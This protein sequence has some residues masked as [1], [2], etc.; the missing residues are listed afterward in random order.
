MTGSR[1]ERGLS[2]QSDRPSPSFRLFPMQSLDIQLFGKL[3]V[4]KFEDPPEST[5]CPYPE[6]VQCVNDLRSEFWGFH[7]DF[8]V[9]VFWLVTSCVAIGPQ[10]FSGSC[11]LHLYYTASQLR[12]SKLERSKTCFT[13]IFPPIPRSPK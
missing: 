13:V 10:R 6:P 4:T 1:Q 3:L 5:Y 9:E 2:E 12:R 7:G 8:Q 11:C